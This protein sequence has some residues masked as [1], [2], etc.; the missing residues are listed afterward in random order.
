MFYVIPGE[1]KQIKSCIKIHKKQVGK[2]GE[3]EGEARR[4]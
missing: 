1:W 3:G 4:G 2:L